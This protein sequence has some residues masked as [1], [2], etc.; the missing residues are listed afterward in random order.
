MARNGFHA[1]QLYKKNAWAGADVRQILL[2]EIEPYDG[3]KDAILISGRDLF[4]SY[5]AAVVFGM[6]FHE[7]ATNAAKYGA[8]AEAGGKVQVNWATDYQGQRV[9]DRM[10]GTRRT[11]CK[12]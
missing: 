11:A 8:L 1:K 10:A 9:H 5:R 7:L 3:E 6:I 12:L 4:V 2:A